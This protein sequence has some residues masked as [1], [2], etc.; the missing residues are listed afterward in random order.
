M[1]FLHLLNWKAD[2][3]PPAA[4]KEAKKKIRGISLPSRALWLQNFVA[5]RRAVVVALWLHLKVYPDTAPALLEQELCKVGNVS[6][7]GSC[8]AQGLRRALLRSLTPGWCGFWWPS[9]RSSFG[10]TAAD[11]KW[12]ICLN[13]GPALLCWLLV[14]WTHC[15]WWQFAVMLIP[16]EIMH[17]C[18][19]VL[20]AVWNKIYLPQIIQTTSPDRQGFLSEPQDQNTLLMKGSRLPGSI[21]K[22]S[23][24][25]EMPKGLLTIYSTVGKA[26]TGGPAKP[27]WWLSHLLVIPTTAR[28]ARAV[29]L[30]S[31]QGRKVCSVIHHPFPFLFPSRSWSC[32]AIP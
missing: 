3:T 25:E 9:L 6:L 30:L 26:R 5:Q 28:P 23:Q 31:R 20:P 10:V 4:K 18:A 32:L 14:G 17:Q 7:L 12:K 13:Q 2:E 29:G 19:W 22:L 11:P 8:S 21:E 15:S 24:S 1:L 16:L 27:T